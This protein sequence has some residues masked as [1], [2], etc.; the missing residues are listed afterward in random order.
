MLVIHVLTQTSGGAEQIA[1]NIFKSNKGAL[2]DSYIIYLNNPVNIQLENNEILI[3]KNSYNLNI[4]SFLKTLLVIYKLS[5]NHKKVI[6]HSHLFQTLYLFPLI[7]IF[8]KFILI[9]TEHNVKN[10]RRKYFFLRPIEKFI[11]SKYNFIVSVSSDVK[12]SLKSWLKLRTN[13]ENNH[14]FITIYNGIKLLN[15]IKRESNQ[16]K[17][18]ILSVGRLIP[19]KGFDISIKAIDEIRDIVDVYQILGSGADKKILEKLIK[20]YDLEK[21]VKLIGFKKNISSWIEKSSLGLV[22]SR[23]EGFSLASLEMLSTGLPVI[24][25]SCKGLSHLKKFPSVIQIESINSKK[26]AH[27]IRDLYESKSITEKDCKTSA[28]LCG[29]YDIETMGKTYNKLYMKAFRN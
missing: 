8:K 11:Y 3:N 17:L 16:K 10:K 7:K 28:S 27:R 1:K 19:Q 26:L 25:S 4:F 12:I 24:A 6:L 21:K 9:H 20:E 29:K 18:N 23:Y 2:F 15:Y 22:P 14:K 13:K 5:K